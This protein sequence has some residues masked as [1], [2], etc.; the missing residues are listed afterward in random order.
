MAESNI[1]PKEVQIL[2]DKVLIHTNIQEVQRE[3]ENG[4]R[5]MYEYD[6]E[7]VSKNKYIEMLKQE[8]NELDLVVEDLTQFLIDKGV[9]Y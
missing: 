2:G 6:E 5:T 9:I 4:V 8:N 3:D 1:K 7:I